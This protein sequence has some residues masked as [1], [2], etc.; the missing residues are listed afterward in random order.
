MKKFNPIDIEAIIREYGIELEKRSNFLPN[1]VL[2]LIRK[3]GSE[4][5]YKYRILINWMYHYY[6]RR[7]TMA[8]I[9]GHYIL[10]KEAINGIGIDE[11]M[12][13][14]TIYARSDLITAKEEA[15]ANRFALNL[16]L[17]D[18]DVLEATKGMEVFLKDG[19]ISPNFLKYLSNAFQ[20]PK[21]V[22]TY[23]I[24]KLRDKIS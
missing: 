3:E 23:K 1:N 2:G 13:Y 5:V 22:I 11:S 18:N 21:E 20:V 6:L 9:L 15:E 10:H 24:N 17:P 19:S 12:E 4:I 7:F 16:L 14:K 8:H